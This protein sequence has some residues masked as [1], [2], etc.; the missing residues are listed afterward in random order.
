MG[1]VADR[2]LGSSIGGGGGG[3]G[4]VMPSQIDTHGNHL[5]LHQDVHHL[6]EVMGTGVCPTWEDNMN[7]EYSMLFIKLKIKVWYSTCSL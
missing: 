1:T 7:E 2:K 5:L 6:Y 3:G 4:G